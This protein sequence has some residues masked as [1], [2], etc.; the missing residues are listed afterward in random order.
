MQAPILKDFMGVR[1]APTTR[2][3]PKWAEA[4]LVTN[5]PFP[6]S[7]DFLVQARSDAQ[8]APT[9]WHRYPGFPDA[10]RADRIGEWYHESYGID[11]KSAMRATQAGLMP[12]FET[13]EESQRNHGVFSQV[14]KQ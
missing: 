10:V 13:V 7:W 2:E 14:R 6:D 12:G 5:I 9:F 3:P 4:E 11:N 1:M 8:K